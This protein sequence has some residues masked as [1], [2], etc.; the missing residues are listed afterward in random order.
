[1]TGKPRRVTIDVDV[2]RAAEARAVAAAVEMAIA[3]RKEA[4]TF[5]PASSLLDHTVWAVAG[6]G[7]LQ[8][9][10]SAEASSLAGT[11]CLDN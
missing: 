10:V 2:D 5:T 9:G 1:M 4:A 8:E 6:A 3:A 11:L 7:C